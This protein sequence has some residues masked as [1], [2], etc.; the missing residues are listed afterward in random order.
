MR[1]SNLLSKYKTN[2]KKEVEGSWFPVD[3]DFEFL[4]AR[5]GG[6]NGKRVTESI[7]KYYIPHMTKIK[8]NEYTEEEIHK[9]SVEAFVHSCILDWRGVKFE[10]S[11][12]DAP[13]DKEYLIELLCESAE[14]L[15]ALRVF[16]NTRDNYKD[17][18]GN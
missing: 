7:A 8:N 4:V 18:L 12:E 13:L 2:Q 14:L 3:G 5:Q 6:A 9:I 11:D 1:K 16:A 15:D 17:E 10:D